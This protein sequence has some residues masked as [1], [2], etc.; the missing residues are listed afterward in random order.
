MP[1]HWIWKHGEQFVDC[2]DLRDWL[3]AYLATSARDGEY[4]LPKASR[5]IKLGALPEGSRVLFARNGKGQKYSQIVGS[6]IV[7]EQP[8]SR[9]ELGPDKRFMKHRPDQRP[10]APDMVVFVP[11]T[12]DAW[13]DGTFVSFKDVRDLGV[14]LPR[15]RYP[16]YIQI[17]DDDFRKIIDLHQSKRRHIRSLL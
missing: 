15:G 3:R 12:V 2:Y 5:I 14:R 17:T 4:Y 11:E 1:K 13:D 16:T 10:E 9:Y 6:A 7:K 8:R